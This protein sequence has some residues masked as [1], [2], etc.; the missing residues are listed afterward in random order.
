MFKFRR[1]RGEES[2][3]K[4]KRQFA[5]SGKSML[6]TV[7]VGLNS[8]WF[9]SS[10]YSVL[11]EFEERGQAKGIID[12]RSKERAIASTLGSLQNAVDAFSADNDQGGLKDAADLFLEAYTKTGKSELLDSYIDVCAKAGMT[13]EEI[14]AKLT[15]TADNSKHIDIAV[16]LYIRAGVREKLIGAGNRTLGLY[17]ETG[18]LDMNSRSRLFDY[19]VEA[20]RSADDKELLIQAGDK[21]L[22]S[23]IEGR[24]LS[25]DKDWVLDAQKAYEAANDKDRL[26]KLGDQYVNLYLKEGLETWLDKATAVYEK[27]EVDFSSKLR[28]LADKVEEKGRSGMA[29]TMRRKAGL[30]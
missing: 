25:R 29:D 10:K 20:Y 3:Q 16:T 18:E 4:G 9:R 7:R 14:A 13:E 30:S 27:A 19:V 6:E 11:K 22:K 5:R 17:L 28:K 21:A 2:K 26:A 23:Q 8:Q 15:D 1:K 12:D 24:R